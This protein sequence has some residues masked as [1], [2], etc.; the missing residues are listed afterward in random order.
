MSRW[1]APHLATARASIVLPAP[2]G[3]YRSTPPWRQIREEFSG[4]HDNC[5]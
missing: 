1:V 5:L 2:G 4:Q 3:P